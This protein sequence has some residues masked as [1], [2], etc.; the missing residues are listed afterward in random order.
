M[1]SKIIESVCAFN[2]D[3]LGI[4]R[5]EDGPVLLPDEEARWLCRALNEEVEEFR[6]AHNADQL[7][8][9]VDALIDLMYFTVGGLWRMGLSPMQIETCFEVIHQANMTK[10]LGQ[11]ASRPTDGTVADAVKPVDWVDPIKA[12]EQL[13]GMRA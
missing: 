13:L 12:L 2:R 4:N 9:S 10:R 11:K 6:E 1:V 8:H 5:V 7:A 3:L